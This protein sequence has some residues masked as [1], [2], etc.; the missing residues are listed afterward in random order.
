MALKKVRKGAPAQGLINPIPKPTRAGVIE[1]GWRKQ[2]QLRERKHVR[3]D[4]R[5]NNGSIGA[6]GRRVA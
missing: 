5:V 2:F 3:A 6:I 1:D 4:K